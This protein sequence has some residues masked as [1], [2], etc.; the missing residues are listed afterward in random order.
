MEIAENIGPNTGT[1]A[2]TT[3]TTLYHTVLY[4]STSRIPSAVLYCA[5]EPGDRPVRGRGRADIQYY[6]VLYS[7]LYCTAL[8]STL[9]H[10]NND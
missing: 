8:C 6:T 9:L 2:G 5:H 1:G 10:I 3:G 4:S 7:I